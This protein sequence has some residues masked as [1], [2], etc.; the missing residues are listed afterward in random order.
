ML[1]LI[2]SG[3]PQQKEGTASTCGWGPRSRKGEVEHRPGDIMLQSG[4]APLVGISRAFQRDASMW[5]P[6][7]F[8]LIAAGIVQ[9]IGS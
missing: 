8:L 6:L 7:A 9:I 1:L 2:I 5:R 4:E 3:K